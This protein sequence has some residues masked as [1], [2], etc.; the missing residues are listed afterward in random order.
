MH[1]FT[2]FGRDAM[3]PKRETLN[4]SSEPLVAFILL[5]HGGQTGQPTST[6]N[7]SDHCCPLPGAANRKSDVNIAGHLING[8]PLAPGHAEV[9]AQTCHDKDSAKGELGEH[10]RKLRAERIV[11]ERRTMTRE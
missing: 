4:A 5:G 9:H 11:N 7:A 3:S 10:G 6:I 1:S 2:F 8:V